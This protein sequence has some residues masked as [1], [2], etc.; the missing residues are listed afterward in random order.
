M[1]EIWVLT[2]RGLEPSRPG[3]YPESS[4]EAFASHLQR[5]F[6]IE[7]DANFVKDGIVVSHDSNLKRITNGEDERAFADM[8]VEELK[9]ISYGSEKSKGR[10]ADLGEVMELIR[11]SDSAINALH[12]KGGY[13]TIENVERLL[14]ELENY[15]DVL[16]KVII[17]DVKPEIAHYIKSKMPSLKLAPSVAHSFDI[18]RYNEAVKGTLISVEDALKFREEEIYDWVWLDEWDLVDSGGKEKKFYSGENFEKLRRAGYRIGLVTPELHG[19]SPWLLGGEAHADASDKERLF[20]RIREIIALEP[21]AVCTDW[22]EEVS[23]L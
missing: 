7:F 18:K 12:L 23:R 3:F 13:Q 20:V 11:G 4:Y 22:P 5:G 9:K 17:F 21:D 14:K 19:S 2:H 16:G 10:I 1:K 6:G 8:R 15:S